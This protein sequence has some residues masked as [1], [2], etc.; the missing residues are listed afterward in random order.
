LA[1]NAALISGAS[2]EEIRKLVAELVAARRN[3]F[4][5][6]VDHARHGWL[7]FPLKPATA[8]ELKEANI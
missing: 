3:L 1:V 4:Q 7:A 8:I 5:S 2:D 6:M